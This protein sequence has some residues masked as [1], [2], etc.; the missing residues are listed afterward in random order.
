MNYIWTNF[1]ISSL[2]SLYVITF[3]M[4]R[5]KHNCKL[6]HLLLLFTYYIQN[7]VLWVGVNW[8]SVCHNLMSQFWCNLWPGQQ[9]TVIVKICNVFCLYIMIFVLRSKTFLKTK[10]NVKKKYEIIG[11][12]KIEEKYENWLITRLLTINEYWLKTR[13]L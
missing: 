12:K 5:Q 2:K 11:K 9:N 10:Q 3:W 13:I 1:H 7:F 8:M 6:K 4:L